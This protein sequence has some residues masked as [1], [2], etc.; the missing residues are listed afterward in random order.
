MSQVV[1]RR[2]IGTCRSDDSGCWP[3]QGDGLTTFRIRY[4]QPI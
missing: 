1:L 2:W 4:S 3:I